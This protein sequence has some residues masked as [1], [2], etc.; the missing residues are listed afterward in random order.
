MR[1]AATLA[2]CAAAPLMAQ[3][4]IGGRPPQPEIAASAMGEVRAAPDRATIVLG[5]QTRAATA[6]AASSAN[7]TRQQAVI[8][9]LR[10]AGVAA[11]EIATVS[12]SIMPDMVYDDSTR[13][14]RVAGYIAQNMVRVELKEISRVGR[15]VDAAVGAGANGV[16][17]LSFSSSQAEGL[18]RSA[19][20]LAVQKACRDASAMAEAA[21]GKLGQLLMA[22]SSDNGGG[23]PMPMQMMRAEAKVSTPI[24]P[25]EMTISVNVDT[26]WAFLAPGMAAGGLTP[27]ACR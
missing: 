27:V 21:G 12:Y 14:S 5:V 9:A 26:R 8:A 15:V 24:E 22:S 11:S 19:L 25:G 3:P 4:A 10:A 20:Q 16:N 2:L 6:A 1:G 18:R 7:A 17:S 23:A 13:S